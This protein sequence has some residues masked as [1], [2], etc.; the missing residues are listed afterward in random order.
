MHNERPDP[1]M[2]IISKMAKL[3]ELV[4]KLTKA[5]HIIED[6]QGSTRTYLLP[7]RIQRNFVQTNRITNHLK[8]IWKP[9]RE[10]IYIKQANDETSI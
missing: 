7:V 8:H 10:L 6:H 2:L 4:T 1:D 3:V 9:D 5:Y